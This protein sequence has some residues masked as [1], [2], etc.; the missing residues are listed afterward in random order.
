MS[1]TPRPT[2]SN[3][4]PVP[5]FVI[6]L[7]VIGV[8]V[9]LGFALSSGQG[10]GSNEEAFIVNETRVTVE[11]S[12][13]DYLPPNISIPLGATVVWTNKDRAEHDAKAD[14]GDWMTPTIEQ[15]GSAALNFPTP[16]TY[17]YHC[18]IHP[19]MKGT[20]TVREEAVPTATAGS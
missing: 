7:I 16:G 5:I 17:T 1:E 15:D 18:T 12:D 2:T 13:Y 8:T 20:I 3:F 4:I 6:S 14:N 9:A 10:D 11:I 19:Y